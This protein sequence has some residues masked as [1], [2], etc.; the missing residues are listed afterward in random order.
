ME[1]SRAAVPPFLEAGQGSFQGKVHDNGLRVEV[2]GVERDL[3]EDLFQRLEIAQANFHGMGLVFLDETGLSGM[4]RFTNAK[5][6]PTSKSIPR[7][8]L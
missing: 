7:I 1:L 8:P 2:N 3:L 5:N 4:R 6:G